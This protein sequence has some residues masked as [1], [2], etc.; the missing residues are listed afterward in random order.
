MDKVMKSI[1]ASSLFAFVA[2]TLTGCASPSKQPDLAALTDQYFDDMD[3]CYG[4]ISDIVSPSVKALASYDTPEQMRTWVAQNPRD[5]FSLLVR[6]IQLKSV[7]YGP[8]DPRSEGDQLKVVVLIYDA[9][10]E[11][12]GFRQSRC[13]PDVREYVED[14][15]YHGIGGSGSRI[16]ANLRDRGIDA[17][18]QR[19]RALL[20]SLM[21]GSVRWSH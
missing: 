4:Y 14:I 3:T 8:L 10:K 12:R 19:R 5:L 17:I 13:G 2:C 6:D 11:M 7:P 18:W 1:F 9:L 15:F 21:A 16:D 20:T